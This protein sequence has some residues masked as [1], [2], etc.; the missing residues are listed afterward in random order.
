MTFLCS[1][2]HSD[3]A[4]YA[5]DNSPFSC[6]KDIESVILQLEKDSKSLLAWVSNNGLKANPDKFHLILNNPDETYY[7]N[8]QNCKIFNRKCEKLLGIKI[9]NSLSFTEHVADLCSK[10]SQKL[11]ALSRVAQFMKTEQLR[12]I[13]KAFIN[14]QFG[15]CPLVWMFHSRK[16][17]NRI[18]K[19]HER[20]LR[21]VYDDNLSS[22]EELLNKDDSFTIHERNIQTLA[23][24]LYKVVNRI[25]PELMSH[26]FPLK[27][28]VKYCSKN[29]FLTRNVH[30]VKYGT[31]TLA[32]LGPKV[33]AIVP[34]ELK[35]ANSLKEFKN[36]IKKWKPD[37]CPCKLCRTYI[38]GVGYID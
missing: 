8:I 34:I 11:H 26:V 20:S 30:M 19:I 29:I 27:E 22:F 13:M 35:E 15:Y 12:I 14:S 10:A 37:K 7:I 5:D 3:I 24:E 33:W 28:S 23:I 1:V 2:S 17:N 9:D 18:N 21:L 25:S 36:K 4:N 16:L 31:E 6:N 32:H 38:S